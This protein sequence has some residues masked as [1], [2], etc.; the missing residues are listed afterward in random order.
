MSV[1]LTKLNQTIER[2]LHQIS[3]ME[4]TLELQS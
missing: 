3:T 2:E 4:S 1:D